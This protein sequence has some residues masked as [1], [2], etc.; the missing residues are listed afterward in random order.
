MDWTLELRDILLAASTLIAAVSVFIAVSTYRKGRLTQQITSL[1]AALGEA[2]RK[3]EELDQVLSERFTSKMGLNIAKQ[4]EVAFGSDISVD[5]L[6]EYFNDRKYRPILL[7]SL[8]AGVD[9][10]R[11]F[12]DVQ[13]IRDKFSDLQ[14]Q[15]R[16]L[17]PN[18][19]AL[20]SLAHNYMA[21]LSL[22]AFYVG[23]I[24]NQFDDPDTRRVTVDSFRSMPTIKLAYGDL[25]DSFAQPSS[26]FISTLP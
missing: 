8:Y 13:E 4:I 9:S 26:M 17:A 24:K 23:N 14:V 12:E 7:R 19:S 11:V 20:F 6:A 16:T 21:S 10:S 3:A 22:S 1:R 25:A 2:L 5:Q 18:T 15:L